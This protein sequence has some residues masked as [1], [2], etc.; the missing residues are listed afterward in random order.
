MAAHGSSVS[1]VAMSKLEEKRRKPG[2]LG[3]YKGSDA[4]GK[5][6]NIVRDAIKKAGGPT[7]GEKGNDFRSMI[8]AELGRLKQ[9]L[10]FNELVEFIKGYL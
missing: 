1:G 10:S 3:E 6:N 8:H 7:S 4:K 5:E 9:N 2:S